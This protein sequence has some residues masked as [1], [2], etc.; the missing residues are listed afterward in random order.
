MNKVKN[1]EDLICWQKARKLRRKFYQLAKPLPD[2]EKYRL[3]NQIRGA[4]VSATSNIAEGFGRYNYQEKIQFV[5]MS[6]ASVFEL[7]DHLYTCIDEGYISQAKFDELY[8]DAVDAAKSINK[9]ISYIF[10]QK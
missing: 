8:L 4:A 5:R 7:Q 9:F 2:Y 3:S 10:D 6:R 1:F